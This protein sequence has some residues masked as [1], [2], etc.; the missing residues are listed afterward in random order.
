MAAKGS[1]AFGELGEEIG[2]AFLP[3]MDELMPLIGPIVELLSELIKA[4]LPLLRPVIMIAVGGIKL[5]I[6]VL[7]TVIGFLNDV[8]NAV[9]GVIDWVGQMVNIAQN[10][11]GQVEG[12]LDQITPWSIAPPV[13]P[14]PAVMGLRGRG[15]RSMAP[16]A[17]HH[18]QRQRPV[19]RPGRGDA[20]GAALVAGQRR[21]RAVHAGPGPEHGVG[22]PPPSGARSSR[23]SS[24]LSGSVW[25]DVT[26][27]TTTAE[28]QWGAPEA[29][30]PLTECEG[31]TLRVSLY[32]PDRTYDPDN[33]ASPM[34]GGLKVGAGM[35]VIV[36]GSPAW[37]GVLQT[38]G[39]DRASEIADLNGLDPI[40]MLSVRVLPAEPDAPAVPDA[41]TAAN[42]RSTSSTWWSG[43]PR[44][45]TSPMAPSGVA[46]SATTTSRAPRSTGSTASGSRNSAACT[47]CVTAGSAGTTAT[48][49]TPPA[50]SAVINCGGVGLTDMW[51]AMG[52]GRVRNR[53]VVV[54][55][56][57]RVRRPAAEP[58]STAR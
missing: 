17:H 12:A 50:S 45:G 30:G 41:T 4:V 27:D 18:R 24:N 40:G 51:K 26:C 49:V 11:V 6:D 53:V 2:G 5:L 15:A 46:Q 48:G 10:A 54:G 58:T 52:L 7:K 47:R 55:R 36:D 37:T 29:L 25:T 28:W 1:Q 16:P 44:S 38:W 43:R 34:Q 31:G 57:R 32:D 13:A 56:L 14:A 8:I 21:L 39:W 19:G 33:P 9:K 42:R 35:R 22:C 3:I 20:R 23:S